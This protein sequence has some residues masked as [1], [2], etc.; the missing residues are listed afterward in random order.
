MLEYMFIQREGD[1]EKVKTKVSEFLKYSKS[2]LVDRYNSM[3]KVGIVGVHEQAITIVALNIVFNKVFSKSP[4]L[5]TDN[6]IVKLTSAIILK[7]DNWEYIV[8]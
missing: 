7:G 8:Q 5:I 1:L 2:E 3:V 4:I 6:I